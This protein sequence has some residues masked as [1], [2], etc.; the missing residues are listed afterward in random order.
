MSKV[1]R[2]VV[3]LALVTVML[4]ASAGAAFACGSGGTPPPPPCTN[5]CLSPGFW[6]NHPEAWPV[7]SITIGGVTYTKA[8]AI[9]NMVQVSGDKS[10]TLFRAL[11]AAELNVRS[12]CPTSGIA[13]TMSSAQSWLSANPLGTGVTGSSTAW[14]CGEPLYL[15]LDAYN[16]NAL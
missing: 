4:G 7:S 6:K 16:N 12:G 9:E 15:L 5:E 13:S 2:F 10:Y 11:V 3:A 14:D 8:Q 1:V